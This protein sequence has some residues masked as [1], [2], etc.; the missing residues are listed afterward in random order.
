VLFFPSLILGLYLLMGLAPVI[1]PKKGSYE[2]FRNTFEFFRALIT[3]FFS[4]LYLITTLYALGTKLSVGKMILFAMGLLWLFLGNSMGKIRHNF[5]FGI[6]TP[7]TLAN[8]EVWNKTHRASGP[9]WVGM[10]IVWMS[11]TLLPERGGFILAMSTLVGIVIF[12]FGYSYFLFGR[13]KKN[14]RP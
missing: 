8:E 1:E 7:W 9:L 11:S 5:T 14:G 3:I 4:F 6:K 2:K 13:I 10:G 12:G